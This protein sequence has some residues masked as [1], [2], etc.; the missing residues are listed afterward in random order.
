MIPV[1]FTY[2]SSMAQQKIYVTVLQQFVHHFTGE[3]MYRV[4]EEGEEGWA[5]DCT[6]TRG[7]LLAMLDNK[8]EGK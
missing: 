7:I 2:Y 5:E 1:H 3:T 4:R 8:V 6:Y